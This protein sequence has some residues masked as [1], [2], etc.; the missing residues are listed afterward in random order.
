MTVEPTAASQR[1][2]TL[3][4]AVIVIAAHAYAFWTF[5]ATFWVD[6]TVYAG[7]G[8]CL[9]SP[10]KMGRFYDAT[11]ILVLSHVGAGEPAIWACAQFLPAGARWPA[12]AITQHALAAGA[13]IFA[14]GNLQRWLP[15][16]WNLAGAVLL[17]YL[18]FHQSFH[19][20]LLTESVSSS[21]FMIGMTLLL[22]IAHDPKPNRR[23]W[24]AFLAVVFAGTQFRGYLGVLLAA[25]AGIVLLWRLPHF[26]WKSWLALLAVSLAA[27]VVFPVYR[28]ACTGIFCSPSGGTNRLVCAAWTNPH[29]SPELLKTLS[30]L[31]W[32]GDPAAIFA[33]DFGYAEA[34]DAGIAWRAEGLSY[35][36]IDRRVG[37]MS[38]AIAL[39][40]P[41]AIFTHVRSGLAGTGM[42][43][44]AFA[45]SGAEPIHQHLS[46][47]GQR[48]HQQSH[49]SWLSWTEHH[50]Y[51]SFG[52]QFFTK[53][54]V[55]FAGG[56][57]AQRELWAALEPHLR[58]T[59]RGRRDPLRLGWLPLDVW[60]LLG[61]LAMAVCIWRRPVLGLVLAAPIAGNFIL[62]TAMPIGNARYVHP[63]LPFYFVALS[64]SC[65]LLL[66][67][68]GIRPPEP[69]WFRRWRLRRARRIGIG[70]GVAKSRG[71]FN[72]DPNAPGV[73][74]RFFSRAWKP[75]GRRAFSAGVSANISRPPS[76]G[77]MDM[78][79]KFFTFAGRW[80]CNPT[81]STRA[82]NRCPE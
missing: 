51:R 16:I 17:S 74:R 27:I 42:I 40:R 36:E 38:R 66:L 20:A 82:K 55:L 68:P 70:A 81:E 4:L 26:R 53:P 25:S 39:D 44:L 35:G 12:I 69:G 76:S 56:D 2:H 50:S 58:E 6:S 33:A 31:G 34:R 78:I 80:R 21:L 28:W 8:D 41:A 5:G 64:A 11:G 45:G 48:R 60:A 7:L 37:A 72:T 52:E 67:R 71:W 15:G 18:P 1:R 54:H 23:D 59:H 79:I 62:M 19:N 73:L 63:I 75:A 10:E 14:F 13:T 30:T 57:E 47:A 61:C 65:G 22:R 46:P 32:P 3:W 29:P 24:A 77:G 9:F 43:T 49:Y